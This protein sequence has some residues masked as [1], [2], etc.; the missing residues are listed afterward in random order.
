MDCIKA[1]QKNWV[2]P[3]MRV[4]AI[5]FHGNEASVTEGSD[6]TVVEVYDGIFPDRPYVSVRGDD[7]RVH[8][9]F[10]LTRFALLAA[11]RSQ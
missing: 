7:G 5:R 9:G 2:R 11:I 1:T 6:Y 10:H 3:G 4:R 8:T